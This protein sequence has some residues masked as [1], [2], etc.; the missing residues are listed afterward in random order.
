MRS[1]LSS[2]ILNGLYSILQCLLLNQFSHFMATN[3]TYWTQYRKK[4]EAAPTQK[5]HK[6]LLEYV[7]QNARKATQAIQLRGCHLGQG[8]SHTIQNHHTIN[9]IIK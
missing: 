7:D 5:Q 2:F 4:R 9:L 3:N 1:P 6:A 8:L